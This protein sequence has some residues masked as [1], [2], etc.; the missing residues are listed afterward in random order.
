VQNTNN[1][2]IKILRLQTFAVNSVLK[3]LK[4][5]FFSTLLLFVFF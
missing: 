3:I 4:P 1:A 2:D 5:I